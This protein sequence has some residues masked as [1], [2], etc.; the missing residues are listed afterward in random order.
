MNLNMRKL[1]DS[2][3]DGLV[4]VSPDGLV[5]YANH[6]ASQGLAPV[7][8]KPLPSD[9]IR[10]QI[11]AAWQGY[12]KLP[13]TLEVD[14][15]GQS[16]DAD[17][18][19]VTLMH[20]P[21]GEE[22]VVVVHNITESQFYENTIN[23]LAEVMRQEL[24][25]PFQGMVRGL[26]VLLEKLGNEDVYADPA[27]LREL[28]DRVAEDGAALLRHMNQLLL[29][30]ETFSR[31][32]MVGNDRILVRDLVSEVL[33]A[34]KPLLA[35]KRIRVSMLGVSEELP[36]LYGSRRWLVQAMGEYIQYMAGQA[37][38]DSEFLLTAKGGGNFIIFHLRNTGQG[39]PVHLR[40]RA[41]LPFHRGAGAP[42]GAPLG[43]GLGLALCKR[44]LEL[45]KGHVRLVESE[46]ET[47]ELIMELPAGGALE[48][49]EA[50]GIEQAQRYAQ[51][52]ARLM[53]RTSM[54]IN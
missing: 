41:F 47:N 48:A 33:L 21:V 29:M 1:F 54:A 10:H 31:A 9:A 46:G 7:V 2:L 22:Y 14:A 30:A 34:A 20:S 28:G 44:V 11:R 51:D 24:S 43:L 23:N 50:A 40:D 53:Q 32:P 52:I 27:L 45:H 15:P 13:L 37:K 19:R 42:D 38:E 39:L 5:R 16:R 36:T 12:V 8:G 17:R 18:L 25:Q 26:E 49:E 6:V 4:I 3:R 35:H